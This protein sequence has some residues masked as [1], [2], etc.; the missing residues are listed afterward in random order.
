MTTENRSQETGRTRYVVA[1]FDSVERFEDAV[2]SLERSGFLRGQI[3]MIASS[4]A[5][6]TR[7][8]R[9]YR[10]ADDPYGD[11]RLP[12]ILF[13]ERHDI[14]EGPVLAIGMPV[15][16][17][18]TVNGQPVVATGGALA[19]A[20]LIAA[21]KRPGEQEI[22]TV[23]GRV[24][25][26]CYADLLHKQLAQGQLLLGLDAVDEHAQDY[27]CYLLK[28]LGAQSVTSHVIARSWAR[29]RES[30]E[31]YIPHAANIARPAAGSSHSAMH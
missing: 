7:L 10:P 25:N 17:G 19:Q 2:D 9:H 18:G 29:D 24:I 22:G 6:K 23:L 30:L 8:F 31:S 11:G 1:G 20:T 14:V 21:A 28:R 15:Y 13:T 5:V 26:P 27:G 16:I 3:N 12:R 4:D